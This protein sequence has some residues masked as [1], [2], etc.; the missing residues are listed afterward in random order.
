M[1]GNTDGVS[2]QEVVV[3]ISNDAWSSN[4]TVEPC[5]P[6]IFLLKATSLQHRRTIQG[7]VTR[8]HEDALVDIHRS[9]AFEV[10]AFPVVAGNG[11]E[12]VG[13]DGLERSTSNS[14][15]RTDGADAMILEWNQSRFKEMTAPE[16][17]VV[18]KCIY[19]RVDLFAIPV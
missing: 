6:E 9:D 2:C 8:E 15:A 18:C 4:Q 16:N 19:G 10:V 13:P 11:I 14:L 12:E 3:I 7:C 17:M 1:I 5:L